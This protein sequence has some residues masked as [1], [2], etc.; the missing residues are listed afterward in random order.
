MLKFLIKVIK[1]CKLKADQ[2]YTQTRHIRAY[3]VTLHASPRACFYLMTI[4]SMGAVGTKFNVKLAKDH[5]FFY[6]D[7]AKFVS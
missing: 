6:Y 5:S 7:N 2:T 1:S 3:P 4:V